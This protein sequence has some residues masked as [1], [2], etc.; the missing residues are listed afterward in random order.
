MKGTQVMRKFT[1]ISV[2]AGAFL[3]FTATS[4]RAVTY[5]VSQSS[6]NDA[7]TGQ[8]AASPW[9]TLAKASTAT[10]GPGDSLLLK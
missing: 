7:S 10:Y 4:A 8:A 3:A 9:K 5:Y 2:V 6:G 1:V